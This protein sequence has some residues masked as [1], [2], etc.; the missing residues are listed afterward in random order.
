MGV[1]AQL[2]VRARVR[3]L[4]KLPGLMFH[5]DHRKVC[6]CLAKN[7]FRGETA[8][9]VAGFLGVLSSHQ[10]ESILYAD[11]LVVQNLNTGLPG[12]FL[13]AGI[14]DFLFGGGD[15]EAAQQPFRD[16]MVAENAV[17]AVFA[18]HL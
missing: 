6:V 2:H 16:V 14:P 15:G 1:A 5:H 7:C 18:F 11:H 3:Q 4:L 8:F 12:K 13:K 10:I 9:S 17:Y